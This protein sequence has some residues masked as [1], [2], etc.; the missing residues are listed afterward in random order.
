VDAVAQVLDFEPDP[1]GKF[2][3]PRFS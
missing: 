1:N 3:M 2:Q